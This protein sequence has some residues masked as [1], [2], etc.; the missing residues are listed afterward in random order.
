MDDDP[1]P[2]VGVGEWVPQRHLQMHML[3]RDGGGGRF[4]LAFPRGTKEMADMLLRCF[5]LALKG[6]C[7]FSPARPRYRP[8]FVCAH[9][10]ATSKSPIIQI[11]LSLAKQ[12]ANDT[13]GIRPN[14]T[15][16]AT[17]ALDSSAN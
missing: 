13:D 2:V 6:F 8:V 15:T 17:K 7:P 3:P 12:G 9:N 1:A 4:R 11:C 16:K 5:S 14:H 10:P